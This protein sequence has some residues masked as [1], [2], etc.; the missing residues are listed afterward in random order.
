MT[1]PYLYLILDFNK[2]IKLILYKGRLMVYNEI[3]YSVN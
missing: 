2:N 3:E 1:L